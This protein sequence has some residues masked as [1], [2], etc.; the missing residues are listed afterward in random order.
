MQLRAGPE[1]EIE[2]ANGECGR[3]GEAETEAEV[4]GTA[5]LCLVRQVAI[6]LLAPVLASGLGVTKPG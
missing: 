1:P 2:V 6:T 3:W 5:R 4:R